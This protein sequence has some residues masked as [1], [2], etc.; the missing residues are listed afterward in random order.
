MRNISDLS[1][2]NGELTP[3]LVAGIDELQEKPDGGEKRD[4]TR[5]NMGMGVRKSLTPNLS[6]Q[7][8]IRALR[9]LD[10]NQTE[11]MFNVALNWTFGHVT[12]PAQQ[13]SQTIPA[14]RKTMVTAQ[15]SPAVDS[16]QDG[17]QDAVDLCPATIPGAAVDQTGCVAMEEINLMVT[18]DFD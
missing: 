12:K 9:S 2:W 13:T 5:M 11:G 1:P 16:D 7:G 3:F 15:S 10:Y 8:D 17:I 6:L 18:F 4:D 14:S